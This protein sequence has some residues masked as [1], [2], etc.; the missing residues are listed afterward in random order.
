MESYYNQF[1]CHIESIPGIWKVTAA[2]ILGKIGDITRLN[3]QFFH[4]THLMTL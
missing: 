3:I 1:D 4:I 2:I